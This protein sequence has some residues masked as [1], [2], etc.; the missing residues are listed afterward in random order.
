[1]R[2]LLRAAAIFVVV[3]YLCPLAGVQAAG[4]VYQ[5]STINALLQGVYDGETTLDELKRHGDF[6]I[7][8]FDALDGEMVVLE[9]Q[10]YQ[11]KDTGQVI[12][13]DGAAKTPFATVTFFQPSRAV[14]ANYIKDY[15]QL[16]NALDRLIT[17]RNYFYA[18]R[19]DGLFTY[20]KTRSVP[21]QS[22]PYQPLA[23]VT[24]NQPVFEYENI[25]GTLVGFWCPQFV[26]GI[27]VPGYHLHFISDD[28]QKGGHLLALRL[29][30]GIIS[31]APITG[32]RLVLPET[33]GF[34]RAVLDGDRQKEL[35]AA[36]QE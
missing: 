8:T 18:I 22:K 29:K 2:I 1:M 32:F 11:V 23:A 20:V 9:G 14:G 7:G 33:D 3:A 27:N 13:A 21:G 15:E 6:G 5:V 36:E 28:R 30:K 24:K 31:I 26:K 19:V 25:Q 17:D 35:K 16:Q 10:A 12:P 4:E 34:R